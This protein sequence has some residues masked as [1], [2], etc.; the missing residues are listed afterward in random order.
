[1]SF[2]LFQLSPFLFHSSAIFFLATSTFIC[3]YQPSNTFLFYPPPR[4]TCMPSADVYPNSLTNS[5]FSPGGNFI[6][7]NQISFPF[8]LCYPLS[9]T[10]CD[11]SNKTINTR[12]P[13]RLQKEHCSLLGRNNEGNHST[14][15]RG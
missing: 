14:S 4:A 15:I 5:G 6:P 10:F 2:I 12:N 11:F 1:M 7:Y 9:G 13:N 8:S 3:H